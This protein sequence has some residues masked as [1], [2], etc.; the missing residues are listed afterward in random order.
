MNDEKRA[1]STLGI[2][3]FHKITIGTGALVCIAFG[4]RMGRAF[5]RLGGGAN[6]AMA[7]VGILLGLSL[8]AYLRHFHR[9]G[10]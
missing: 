5:D 10:I 1:S 3:R 2:T 6:L 8:L 4:V 7:V 9:N